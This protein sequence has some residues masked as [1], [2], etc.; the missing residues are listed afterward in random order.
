MHIFRWQCYETLNQSQEKILKAPKHMEVKEHPTKEWIDQLGNEEI[1]KYMEANE[2]EN[3][4]VQT[5][6]DTAKEVL[7]GKYIVIQ[8]ISRSKKGPK[9]RT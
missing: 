5:L 8:P 6:W 3:N 2:N 9:Y 1:E 4:I 7:R